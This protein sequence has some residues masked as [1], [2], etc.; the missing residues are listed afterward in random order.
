M[1]DFPDKV[2]P[3]VL[4]A[5]DDPVSAAFLLDAVSSFPAETTLVGS[6][7][8][9]I[10][11]CQQNSFALL[12]LDANLPDGSS[13]LLL[14]QLR[15]TGVHTP[16]LAHTADTSAETAQRLRDAGF[17]DVLH[18]PIRLQQ[19]HHQLER[20][21]HRPLAPFWDDSEALRALGGQ[22]THVQLLRSLFLEELPKQQTRILAAAQTS[23][24][25]SIR[26]ELH[27]LTASCGLV[28]AS[29]LLDAVHAL[30]DDPLDP[31][32]L[33]RFHTVAKEMLHA[34]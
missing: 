3:H 2:L 4:L 14:Q 28:G 6:V 19:L 17:T 7:Q 12:L 25:E 30:R 27:K 9:A 33:Q 20:Y 29:R 8:Q 1:N 16:A 15:N 26:S 10:H 18:K 21:L 24:G 23:D 22:I 34:E 11:A 31:R 5:E 32:G 13:E